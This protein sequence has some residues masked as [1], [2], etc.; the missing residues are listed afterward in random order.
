[1]MGRFFSPT[2]SPTISERSPRLCWQLSWVTKGWQRFRISPHVWIW[3]TKLDPYVDFTNFHP[4]QFHDSN[5]FILIRKIVNQLLPPTCYDE[6][7]LSQWLTRFIQIYRGWML[8]KPGPVRPFAGDVTPKRV[9]GSTCAGGTTHQD[10]EGA[11]I[12]GI[13]L[14][15]YKGCAKH[16]MF[17]FTR[18]DWLVVSPHLKN[19]SQ[20][21][22]FFPLYGKIQ[23]VPNHQP[24]THQ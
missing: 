15:R 14:G 10:L 4:I 16:S 3:R 21:G 7:K 9:S 5:M 24:D 17:G 2:N 1:M 12:S 22:W 13:L 6:S 23:H 18:I 19:I 11:R 20:L 8:R